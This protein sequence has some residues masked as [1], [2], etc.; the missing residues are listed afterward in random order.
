MDLRLDRFASLYVISP[1]LRLASK[2]QSI[3]ILMY[4]SIA[5]EDES[6]RH[7]YFRTSTSP[8]AFAAQIEHLHRN[9]YKTCSPSA[10]IQLLQDRIADISKIVAITFDDGFRNFYENAF[11]VLNKFG[12]GATVYLP[13]AYIGETTLQ[14]NQHDCLTWS[15]VRELQKHGIDFGSHTVTHPYLRSISKEALKRELVD[16]KRAIEEN[17]GSAVESFAYPYGFPQGDME[18]KDTLRAALCDAGYRN[19]VCT[20]VGSANGASDQFFLERLPVNSVDDT[21]LFQAKLDGAYDWIA[22][23]QA[24]VKA[25]KSLAARFCR[26]GSS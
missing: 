1:F 18:F 2:R 20:I 17:T 21:A 16:S 12:F 5:H 10:V 7:A 6:G 8:G 24:G 19:G 15:E 13:T 23:P 4:H 3:P 11:P 26:Q 25:A 14:F 22:K 9:G